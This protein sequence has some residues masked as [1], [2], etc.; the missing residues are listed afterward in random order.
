[1]CSLFA[2]WRLLRETKGNHPFW[3]TKEFT[4]FFPTAEFQGVSAQIR[5]S[6]K[7][8]GDELIPPAISH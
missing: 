2:F 6:P 7:L 5:R 4:G 1:M 8:S 3:S